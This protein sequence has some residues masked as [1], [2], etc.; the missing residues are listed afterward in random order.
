MSNANWRDTSSP[1]ITKPETSARLRVWPCQVVVTRQVVLPCEASCLTR[2]T[3]ATRS[4]TLIPLTTL[5]LVVATVVFMIYLLCL[6]DREGPRRTYC[7]VASAAWI[8]CP[9]STVIKL[10]S[11]FLNIGCAAPEWMYCHR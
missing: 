2:V 11:T 10:E 4:S 5:G 3:S 9:W 8:R 1:P 7:K 6:G